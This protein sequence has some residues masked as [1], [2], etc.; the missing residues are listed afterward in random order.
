MTHQTFVAGLLL[1]NFAAQQVAPCNLAKCSCNKRATNMA[2]SDKKD[3]ILIA[4]ML[5]AG[6]ILNEKKRNM[7]KLTKDVFADIPASI[8]TIMQT[9]K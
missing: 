6:V 3:V 2:S 4:A 7:L 1:R 5:L 8:Y 9:I